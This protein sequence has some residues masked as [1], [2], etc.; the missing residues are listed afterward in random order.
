[1]PQKGGYYGAM[2]EYNMKS[3]PGSK[4]DFKKAYKWYKQG[5][6]EG[7]RDSQW[8]LGT[9][10]SKGIAPRPPQ[11]YAT[12]AILWWRVNLIN[13]RGPE[14]GYETPNA[15]LY[16]IERSKN[17]LSASDI[18]LGFGLAEACAK[19]GFVDC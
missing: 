12:A 5:A 9:M 1:M 2:A 13:Q 14:V 4:V 8:A 3:T 7:Q 15:S 18:R 17:W 19:R 10:Y 16:N 6:E 11:D